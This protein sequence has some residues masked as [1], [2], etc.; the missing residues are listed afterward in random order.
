M[1]R[2]VD[3]LGGSF[4]QGDWVR[5]KSGPFKSFEGEVVMTWREGDVR[6]YA[7]HLSFRSVEIIHTIDCLSIEGI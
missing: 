1:V 6:M 4:K 7:I 5:L 2:Q 3:N